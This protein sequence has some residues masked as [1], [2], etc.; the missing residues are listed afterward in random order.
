MNWQGKWRWTGRRSPCR[1]LAR[2]ECLKR[3]DD[4]GTASAGAGE[5]VAQAFRTAARKRHEQGRRGFEGSAVGSK[6]ER[7][8]RTAHDQSKGAVPFRRVVGLRRAA[9]QSRRSRCRRVTG[10]RQPAV[11]ESPGKK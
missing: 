11:S 10:R 3:V 5:G 4:A 9:H 6:N 1:R 7:G 2:P 8:E